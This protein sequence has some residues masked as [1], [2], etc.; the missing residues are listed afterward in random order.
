VLREGKPL[1]LTAKLESVPETAA[2]PA[3]KPSTK[4]P[5]A[6]EPLAASLEP[7]DEEI[8]STLKLS[9]SLKGVY[10]AAVRPGTPTDEAGLERGM[11][12]VSVNGKPVTTEEEAKKVASAVGSGGLVTLRTLL[13]PRDGKPSRGII[14]IPVP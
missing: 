2:V 7:L 14:N 3:P 12:I 9:D 1:Q 11:I 8:R 13:V 4:K 5:K 6:D 10:V